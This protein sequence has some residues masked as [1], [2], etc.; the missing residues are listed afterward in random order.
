MSQQSISLQLIMTRVPPPQAVSV[1][2]GR[3]DLRRFVPLDRRFVIKRPGVNFPWTKCMHNVFVTRE[4]SKSGG[5]LQTEAA[6]ARA[7]SINNGDGF[8]C[9]TLWWLSGDGPPIT[10]D[11]AAPLKT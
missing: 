8:T 10:S 11:I 7:G 4:R 9:H 5:G 2:P 6:N 1:C 3:N